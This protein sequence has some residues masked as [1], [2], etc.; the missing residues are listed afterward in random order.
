MLFR[1][2]TFASGRFIRSE[3]LGLIG[4]FA[5]I[6]FVHVMT[7]SGYGD[8]GGPVDLMILALIWI[9]G[10]AG[11]VMVAYTIQG[12]IFGKKKAS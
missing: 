7:A 5:A 8:I 9:A 10:A 4:G 3:I 12:L 6:W 1:E 11:T 2:R